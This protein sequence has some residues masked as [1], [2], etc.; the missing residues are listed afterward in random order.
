MLAA[1]VERSE[2]R[3]TSE[4]VAF[5]AGFRDRIAAGIVHTPWERF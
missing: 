1:N 4:R 5:R 2:Q 3:I